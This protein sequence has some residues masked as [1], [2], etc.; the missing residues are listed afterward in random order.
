M[1][2]LPTGLSRG[3]RSEDAS[4]LVEIVEGKVRLTNH[5]EV[6]LLMVQLEVQLA[7]S[8]FDV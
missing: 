2:Y 3:L 7:C 1:G 8:L 4:Q 6:D 5:F